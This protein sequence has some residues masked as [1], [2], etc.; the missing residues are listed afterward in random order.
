[1][2]NELPDS[3]STLLDLADDM[4]D[5]LHDHE[6][7]L[8]IKQWTEASL[9]VLLADTRAKR[10]AY[11]DAQKAEDEVTGQRKTANSNAKGFIATAKRMLAGELGSA[12][13]RQ[14]E[15]VGW[16]PGTTEAPETIEGRRKLL[17]KLAPWLVARP[18]KD[19]PSQNFTG[20]RASE[21]FNA[22]DGALG[23]LKKKVAARVT[24]AGDDDTAE[25]ALRN[26]MSGLAEELARLILADSA[27]WYYFGLVPPAKAEPPAPP[28][29]L[30]I[31]QAGPTT[32]IAGCDRSPRG[33]KYIFLLQVLGRDAAPIPQ[34]P[35]RD[36]QITLEELPAG[37]TVKVSVFTT[38]A[39]GKSPTAGSVELKLG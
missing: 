26:G 12:P 14:W 35:K 30:A 38:N 33:Q 23:G 7:R 13:N 32:V 29:D 2:S 19:V 17:E 28:E 3:F 6:A 36:P 5:G 16:P 21:I 20:V 15:E 25:K 4:I 10:K 31:H 1:M 37:S 39:A 24:A 22:L 9:T 27:D 34:E 8:K 18:E 11:D